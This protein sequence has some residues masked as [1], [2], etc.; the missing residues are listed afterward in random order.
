VRETVPFVAL[1][2]VKKLPECDWDTIVY[3]SEVPRAATDP[4]PGGM[5]LS[6]GR[7]VLT[8]VAFDVHDA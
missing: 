1:R 7:L 5:L 6:I 4:T 8:M 3:V 2:I